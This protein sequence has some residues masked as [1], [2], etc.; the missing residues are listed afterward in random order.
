MVGQ[1][2]WVVGDAWLRVMKACGARRDSGEWRR[3]F[4]GIPNFKTVGKEHADLHTGVAGVVAMGDG[5]LSMVSSNRFAGE[6]VFSTGTCV[7][8]AARADG[9]GDFDDM[10]KSTASSTEFK[11]RAFVNLWWQAEWLA[12]FLHVEAVHSTLTSE[13]SR[14]TLRLAAKKEDGVA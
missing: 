7:P 14:K 10:A 6:F 1:K 2:Q 11:N 8:S 13:V 4:S 12:D 9:A 5:A 3:K